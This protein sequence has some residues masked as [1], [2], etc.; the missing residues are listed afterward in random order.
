MT[1]RTRVFSP[2]GHLHILH[3]VFNKNVRTEGIVLQA[4]I[5]SLQLRPASMSSPIFIHLLSVTLGEM[6]N[7]FKLC[8]HQ[9]VVK[10]GSPLRRINVTLQGK[11]SQAKPTYF[12]AINYLGVR[13][14]T[15]QIFTLS[16][17][18]NKQ[19]LH[20]GHIAGTGRD[21]CDLFSGNMSDS[22]SSSSFEF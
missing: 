15:K 11:P 5:S 17:L 2:S 1:C 4:T 18:H 21:E 8:R 13:R 6:Y 10:A 20:C 19:C 14:W 22:L 7:A 16:A 3:A 9:R 12:I